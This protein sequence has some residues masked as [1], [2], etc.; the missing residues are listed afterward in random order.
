MQCRPVFSPPDDAPTNTYELVDPK[1][2]LSS[3]DFETQKV[4]LW[5][6]PFFFL[7][8]L[9]ASSHGPLNYQQ[10][11]IIVLRTK[12]K[13]SLAGIDKV[14]LL[15]TDSGELWLQNVAAEHLEVGPCEMFGF[16]LGTFSE[17]KAG[18]FS[19]PSSLN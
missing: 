7:N 6:A 15:L 17:K 12:A 4:S 13:S 2:I 5:F 1:E 16:N 11:L 8:V 3:D 14:H 10:T 19:F 18:I 9:L